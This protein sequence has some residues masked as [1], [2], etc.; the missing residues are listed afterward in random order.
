MPDRSP[1]LKTVPELPEM[2]IIVRDLRANIAGRTIVDRLLLRPEE[3]T[4]PQTVVLKHPLHVRRLRRICEHGIL[5]GAGRHA[6]P[7]RQHE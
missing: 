7:H 6:G 5:Q 2:E 4:R 1:I 3:W